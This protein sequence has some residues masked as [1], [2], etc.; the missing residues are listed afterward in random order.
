MKQTNAVLAFVFLCLVGSGLLWVARRGSVT[1]ASPSAAILPEVSVSPLPFTPSPTITN[2]PTAT[3]DYMV[4][5]Q[6]AQ[7]TADEARRVNAQATVEYLHFVQSQSNL[8]AA[9]DV[10][11]QE[12]AAWTVTAALT[13]IPLTATQQAAMNTLVP[14]QQSVLAGQM[15]ATKEAPTQMVALEQAKVSAQF[16]AIQARVQIFAMLSLG[17][18]CL[19]L[20][21]FLARYPLQ[22]RQDEAQVEPV[23]EQPVRQSILIQRETDHGD[24]FIEREFLPEVPCTPEQLAEFATEIT[25]GRKTMRIN[26]WEGDGTLWIRGQYLLFRKWA[27]D[28]GFVNVAAQGQLSPTNEFLNFLMYYIDHGTLQDGYSF[29][30][31]DAATGAPHA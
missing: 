12:V 15:T 22:R 14:Y 23:K 20:A 6:I 29:A 17:A 11:T 2:T 31:V 26:H 9:A 1:P 10:R 8:T 21:W 5:A 19:S 7:A 27:R 4:T 25:Q 16:A 18:F 28:C 30:V 3:V 24:G 13:S